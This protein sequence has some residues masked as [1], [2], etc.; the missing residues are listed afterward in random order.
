[1]SG[2]FVVASDLGTGGCKTVAVDG[3]GNVIA[4]ARSEY[5]TH[6]VHPGW[7]EQNPDDWV[8]A[9]SET[10][11]AVLDQVDAPPRQVVAFGLDGTTHNAVLLDATGQPLRPSI[12][13]YD[14]RSQDECDEIAASWGEKIFRRTRNSISPL[15]TWPQLAW[16][17]KN[18]PDVWRAV[19]SVLFQKDYVRNRLAP[20]RVT[21]LIDVEGSL[22]FDPVANQWVDE[23]IED[24]GLSHD[25]LPEVVRSTDVVGQIDAHGSD[26]TGLPE[27]TP[28]V[29]GVSDTAAEVFGAGAYQPG[30]GMIKLASVGRIATVASGPGDD[31]RLFN[32]RHIIEGLWY[33]GTGVKHAA[34]AYRWLHET[35]CEDDSYEA[36]DTA[37]GTVPA[38]CE[39]MLFLPHLQGAWAPHWDDELRAGFLGINMRHKRSH[40]M[41]AVMEGVAFALRGALRVM[42]ELGL[43]MDEVRLI[44]QGATSCLW[45]QIVADVLG[46]PILVPAERDA[47]YGMA[48]IIGIAVGLF[49]SDPTAIRDL[50]RVADRREPDPMRTVIYDDLFEI[51]QSADK[52]LASVSRRLTDFEHRSAAASTGTC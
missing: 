2:A 26:L 34:S 42:E 30:Q 37:A 29:A 40:F 52:S 39:G 7:C 1:M 17:K 36:M 27:G 47:A 4:S 5:P 48:L 51:Y 35:L 24:L 18:E 13:F 12:Q 6:Y 25:A 8:Q 20:S 14:R 10:T 15:W 44:G 45:A 28:V 22:L 50:I 32:Y 31:P 49:P 43:G 33:P 16:V 9:V 23:F 21:D 3:T 38:G 46:C 11:R 19:R 41:R